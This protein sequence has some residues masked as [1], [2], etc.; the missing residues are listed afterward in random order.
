MPFGCGQF[1]VI[2]VDKFVTGFRFGFL[3]FAALVCQTISG[4]AQQIEPD[5]I[6]FGIVSYLTPDCHRGPPVSPGHAV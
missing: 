6:V 1:F 5:F 3:A 2:T 4:E